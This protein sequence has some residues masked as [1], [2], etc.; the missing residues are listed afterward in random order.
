MDEPAGGDPAF[1]PLIRWLLLAAGRDGALLPAL[2]HAAAT[3]HRRARRQSDLLRLYLPIFATVAIGGTVT[4]LYSLG[5]FL[6]YM[7]LIRALAR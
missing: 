5:L 3:Y 1:P 6:P 4:A 7:A 2:R